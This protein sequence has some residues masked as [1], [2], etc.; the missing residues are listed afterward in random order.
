MRFHVDDSCIGCGMCEGTC[1]EV[2]SLNAD[3]LAVAVD[4]DVPADQIDSAK[5]A[6]EN[7]PVNAISQED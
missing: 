4:G 2:F 1:P 7:C 3:A 6:M 5:E